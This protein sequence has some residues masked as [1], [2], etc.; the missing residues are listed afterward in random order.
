MAEPSIAVHAGSATVSAAILTLLPGIDANA[1]IGALCGAVL[2]FVSTQQELP[3][4]IRLV[5]LPISFVIGYLG[6]PAV[7]GE[8]VEAS[9]VSAFIG[10]AITVTAGLRVIDG[11]RTLDLKTWLGGKK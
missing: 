2:F 11:V 4:W 3:L 5:Y 7:L 1:V 10:A 6:G 9:A 8:M